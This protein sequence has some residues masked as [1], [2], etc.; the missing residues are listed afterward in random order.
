MSTAREQTYMF[1][2]TH[3]RERH[4]LELFELVRDPASVRRLDRTGVGPD[5]RCLEL[6]AGHG[7]I[8]R[9]LARRTEPD[10]S[11][12]AIDLEPGQLDDTDE[13]NLEVRR[14]D[15]LD[16]ELP[17]R[18]FDLIHARAVLEHLPDRTRAIARMASWLAPGGWLVVE[19]VDWLGRA[20]AEPSWSSLLGAYDDAT[21]PIDWACGRELVHELTA[22]GLEVI[23]ADADLDA[24]AGDTPLAEWYRESFIALRAAARAADTIEDAEIDRQLARLQRAR[25]PAVQPERRRGLRRRA[26]AHRSQRAGKRCCWTRTADGHHRTPRPRGDESPSSQEVR[27]DK[28]RPDKQQRR[29]E[30]RT[31]R[32][33][34]QRG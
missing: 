29:A 25:A 24:I 8:A 34:R 5:W 6:G 17:A 28:H 15:L 33:D 2:Q 4:R 3:E 10:G 18:A 16:I 9:W 11:V 20:V 21:P 7:S 27:D 13:P 12:L 23:D 31:D 22:A 19:E 32:A 26:R 14:A 1:D 30:D